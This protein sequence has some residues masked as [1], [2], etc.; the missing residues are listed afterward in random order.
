MICGH[1]PVRGQQSQTES[2]RCRI[3][4]FIFGFVDSAVCQLQVGALLAKQR[5]DDYLTEQI[6]PLF[7]APFLH[8]AATRSN[9]A[10]A[11][12][13][14]ERSSAFRCTPE[15]DRGGR[16]VTR[17]T[18]FPSRHY[19]STSVGSDCQGLSKAND[20]TLTSHDQARSVGAMDGSDQY[21]KSHFY[22][23]RTR[24]LAS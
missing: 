11:G 12:P 18:R 4:I 13:G 10:V 22:R 23:Q 1:P 7:R 9:A 20:G 5:S 21:G 2:L 14:P 17:T 3:S 24:V 16:Q 8:R 15:N 19:G 6:I